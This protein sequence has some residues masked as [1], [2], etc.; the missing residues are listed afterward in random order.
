MSNK[1]NC[2]TFDE[3]SVHL[4]NASEFDSIMHRDVLIHFPPGGTVGDFEWRIQFMHNS[5]VLA[6]RKPKKYI[7]VKTFVDIEKYKKNIYYENIEI[8]SIVESSKGVIINI[9]L[10]SDLKMAKIFLDTPIG[11]Y[12]FP[13]K[14]CVPYD[15][16]TGIPANDM[17]VSIKLRKNNNIMI[18]PIEKFILIDNVNLVI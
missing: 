13:I 10:L 7:P 6:S 15:E 16:I 3:P 12:I 4:N 17:N 14:C 9:N 1:C 5:S 8:L 18:E 2:N 11:E